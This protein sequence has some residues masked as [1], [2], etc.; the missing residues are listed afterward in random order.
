VS[1]GFALRA[2]DGTVVSRGQPAP[3]KPTPEGRLARLGVVPL[4]GK[5]PGAYELI[6]DLRDEVSGRTMEVTEPFALEPPA[7]ARAASAPRS[8]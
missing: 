7:P 4:E 2:G 3:I 8:N 1:A 5:A 6:L